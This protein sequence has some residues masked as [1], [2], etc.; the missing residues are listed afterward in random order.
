MDHAFQEIEC[1]CLVKLGTVG[2][3]NHWYVEPQ[4]WRDFQWN[5]YTSMY[6]ADEY[7]INDLLTCWIEKNCGWGKQN[8]LYI[9]ESDVPKVENTG[10]KVAGGFIVFAGVIII[11]CCFTCHVV[12]F[13]A[14]HKQLV[15]WSRSIVQLYKHIRGDDGNK[16]YNQQ[17][18]R[19]QTIEK[20][21]YYTAYHNR[22]FDLDI[23]EDICKI[24]SIFMDTTT[25]SQTFTN[26][27][28]P[29]LQ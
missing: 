29:L 6:T 24:L 13:A 1:R 11:F 2:G 12:I 26:D 18:N 16:W 15:I 27:R 8:T 14:I 28:S 4:A 5:Y 17:W 9:E 25:S 10:A 23:G 21:D 19:L 7:E 20:I 22:I 3:L